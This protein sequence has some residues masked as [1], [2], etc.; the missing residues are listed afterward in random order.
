VLRRIRAE[1]NVQTLAVPASTPAGAECD[2]LGTRRPGEPLPG[3]PAVTACR[4]R[5]V[6]DG[7]NAS[8]EP[9]TSGAYR[10]P[11]TGSGR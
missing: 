8:G 2:G 1:R 9:V 11:T 10:R 6:A 4:K 3:A 7:H 5:H